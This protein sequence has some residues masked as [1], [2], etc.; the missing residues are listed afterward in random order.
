ML[1]SHRYATNDAMSAFVQN[2]DQIVNI[3]VGELQ[4]GVATRR[5]QHL[6]CIIR[7]RNAENGA[8]L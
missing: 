4:T 7:F 1:L 3:S 5:R 6:S 2:V 8:A